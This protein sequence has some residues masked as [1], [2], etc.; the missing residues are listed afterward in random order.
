M[1]AKNADINSRSQDMKNYLKVAGHVCLYLAGF[2][3][4][5]MG[6]AAMVGS[7]IL[8]IPSALAIIFLV[9]GS[10]SIIS[11]LV[12]SFRY[13]LWAFFSAPL[14]DG[15]LG[16]ATYYLYKNNLLTNENKN[17]INN[18]KHRTG[19]SPAA[20]EHALIPAL[21]ILDDAGILNQDSFSA[22]SPLTDEGAAID[23][24]KGLKIL[25]GAGIQTKDNINAISRDFHN[26]YRNDDR[27]RPLHSG[28]L[29]AR[30][31][32]N[33]NDAGIL[34]SKNRDVITSYPAYARGIYRVLETMCETMKLAGIEGASDIYCGM[35]GHHFDKNCQ[36]TQEK[37][38]TIFSH[39]YPPTNKEIKKK[40][41]C[42][43]TQL[44]NQDV[45][46]EVDKLAQQRSSEKNIQ[47]YANKLCKHIRS[48]GHRNT[49][50]D[51]HNTHDAS[52]N[53]PKQDQ[54]STH[55]SQRQQ[56]PHGCFFASEAA[57]DIDANEQNEELTSM[58]K[59]DNLTL[60]T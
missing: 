19:P 39:A 31:L 3:L 55:Y 51:S 41:S 5:G 37:F 46:M 60:N 17:A 24:A 15:L 59:S 53:N 13:H 38:D 1:M 9:L 12:M 47:Q 32:K 56:K 49:Q 4:L 22:I 30:T 54:Q 50:R 10:L 7:S 2:A 29:I 57:N 26:F 18:M 33:M 8:A 16:E 48:Q 11:G 44:L 6:I 34:N 52:D 23:V 36:L 40:W 45:F 20:P 43:P 21:E 25:N 42:L 27:C 28:R 14:L 58:Q 35:L